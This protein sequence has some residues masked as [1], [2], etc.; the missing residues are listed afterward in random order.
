MRAMPREQ[1]L[2]LEQPNA[3]AGAMRA[4]NRSSTLPRSGLSRPIDQLAG[5]GESQTDLKLESIL[6]FSADLSGLRALYKCR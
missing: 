6:S 2:F 4:R 1:G 3:L 5:P